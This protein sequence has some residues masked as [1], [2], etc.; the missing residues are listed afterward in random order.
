MIS[1][2]RKT[3]PS[4]RASAMKD[5]FAILNGLGV[6]DE[7]N[8]NKSTN[9]YFYPQTGST[10]EFFSVEDAMRIRSRRRDYLWMNEANEFALED[11][12][13]LGM[14]TNVQ[15][16]MDYNPSHQYHWI[17]DEVQTREDCLILRSSYL[18]NPFLP[19]ELVHEIEGYRNKDENYWKIYGLGERGSTEITIY[20][21]WQ[22]CD[23]LPE[24][25]D[26]KIFGVDFGFNNP[27]TLTELRDKDQDWYWKEHLYESHLTNSD[28]IERLKQF[29]RDKILT[30]TDYIYCDSAEPQRI[31][32]IQDAG[33]N[34][35]PAYKVD[36]KGGIDEIKSHGFF[37][38][39]DSLNIQKEVK[40]Y[41][42]K[43]KD[44]KALEE[45]VKTNDHALDGGRYAIATQE[46]NQQR[47][48][49][50]LMKEESKNI[51][52]Q[53]KNNLQDFLNRFNKGDGIRMQ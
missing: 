12:R 10:V 47:G 32:E 8:H 41:S 51:K 26:N 11:Y 4:L 52:P 9:S 53:E 27:T 1:I 18:D 21:H 7:A 24:Q 33:F 20:T 3:M 13:Q 40:K 43:T 48:M 23:A 17:Y 36:V 31:K 46:K 37:I 14:R 49:Y 28:F 29:E 15:I 19:A 35:L 2:V 50:A 39:K 34:A 38:T 16:F 45:P 30:F 42:W 5:F 6:Y 44:G 25:F 22:L